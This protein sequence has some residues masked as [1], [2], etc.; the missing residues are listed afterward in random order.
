M[1]NL[2]EKKCTKCGLV[3]SIEEF[4]VSKPHAGGRHSIC[5]PCRHEAGKIWRDNNREKKNE[6]RRKRYAE[7]R[8]HAIKK[9]KKEKS[10]E[11]IEARRAYLKKK[12]SERYKENKAYFHEHNRRWAKK[13]PGRVREIKKRFIARHKVTVKERLNHQITNS[14]RKSLKNGSK[15]GRP[16][17]SLVGYTIDQLKRHIEKQFGPEMN[18]GNHGSYWHIDHKIPIAAFNFENPEDIDFKRCWALGNLQLLEAKT[19]MIKHAKVLKPFQ[20]SLTLAVDQ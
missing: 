7:N 6:Q 11:E 3:K 18:W 4:H 10:A 15:A 17:E 13:N 1:N 20:P 16:W 5:T 9:P 12:R 2:H 14:I 8:K 19:N